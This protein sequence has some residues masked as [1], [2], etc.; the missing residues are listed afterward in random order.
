MIHQIQLNEIASILVRIRP[1]CR[2]LRLKTAG[3]QSSA[4]LKMILGEKSQIVRIIFKN[5]NK[6]QNDRRVINY[7]P[8]L[9]FRRV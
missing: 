2:Y 4:L 6:Q 9:S 5:K 7:S 8:V 3:Q 1:I